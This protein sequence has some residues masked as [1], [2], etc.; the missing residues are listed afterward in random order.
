MAAQKK[1]TAEQ[2]AEVV[3]LLKDEHLGRNDISRR[4]GLGLGTV[5]NIV[6]RAGLTFDR[7]QTREATAARQDDLAEQRTR[8]IQLMRD[9]AEAQ[10]RELRDV[11]NGTK[12]WRTVL[13]SGFGEEKVS[14]LGFI[15]ARDYSQINQSVGYQ[16]SH[17]AKLESLTSP[18]TAA[19]VSI[20]DGLAAKYGLNDGEVRE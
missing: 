18:A 19:A 16:I 6:R 7:V 8:I 9:E 15:P 11:R 5:T 13:R 3:R 2:R 10:L 20:L 14:E 17:S 4:T 12:P 1:V